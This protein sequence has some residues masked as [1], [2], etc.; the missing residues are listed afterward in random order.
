[1]RY[2]DPNR[3]QRLKALNPVDRHHDTG[4]TNNEDG[5]IRECRRPRVPGMT[6]M[7]PEERAGRLEEMR[8]SMDTMPGGL[9]DY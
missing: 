9:D 7:L 8:R 5:Y 4:G 1:M 6:D 2:N 3:P